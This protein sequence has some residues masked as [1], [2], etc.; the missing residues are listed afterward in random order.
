MKIKITSHL[1]FKMYM[2][3]AAM[4]FPGHAQRLLLYNLELNIAVCYYESI[5]IFIV[6]YHV[7]TM[8]LYVVHCV[9]R[10]LEVIDRFITSQF[11]GI[12]VDTV[13][14]VTSE[15]PQKFCELR[16]AITLASIYSVCNCMTE[17][18]GFLTLMIVVMYSKSSNS[19]L[20]FFLIFLL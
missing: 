18:R 20:P 16:Q 6:C 9:F 2:Y 4:S 7:V 3:M 17:S 15:H 8:L 13:T 5:T 10:I 12:V 1:Q 14:I 19:S 11:P